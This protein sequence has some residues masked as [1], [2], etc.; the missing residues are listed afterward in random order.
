MVAR[1]TA[2][3]RT[4]SGQTN[5]FGVADVGGPARPSLRI[6]D[7]SP[8]CC[9][10]CLQGYDF[11]VSVVASRDTPSSPCGIRVSRSM[12]FTLLPEIVCALV[13]GESVNTIVI[14]III[15]S[16]SALPEN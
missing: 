6:R 2:D 12:L 5:T 15:S 7:H 8:P 11:D 1:N 3:K 16:S 10:T 14:L 13:Y 4:T 9:L